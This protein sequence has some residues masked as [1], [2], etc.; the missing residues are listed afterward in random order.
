MMSEGREVDFLVQ[1]GRVVYRST[2]LGDL[3]GESGRVRFVSE[4]DVAAL[5]HEAGDETVEGGVVVCAGCAEGE[6]VLSFY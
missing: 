2:A 5:D 1:C 6:E 3:E 4:G